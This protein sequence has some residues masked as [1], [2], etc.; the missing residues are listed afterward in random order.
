MGKLLTDVCITNQLHHEL[1]LQHAVPEGR[2]HPVARTIP[3]C[4]HT[5]A[6]AED[7]RAVLQTHTY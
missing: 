3:A 1:H 4:K 6:L 5:F 2:Q 7:M